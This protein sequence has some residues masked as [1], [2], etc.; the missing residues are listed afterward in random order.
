[1]GDQ[2]GGRHAGNLSIETKAGPTSGP[3]AFERRLVDFS[4]KVSRRNGAGF[5]G[6]VG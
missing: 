2:G 5:A 4:G 6:I 1:M 3:V